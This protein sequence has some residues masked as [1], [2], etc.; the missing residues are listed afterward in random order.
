MLLDSIDVLDVL[1]STDIV[2]IQNDITN[3]HPLHLYSSLIMIGGQEPLKWQ[4]LTFKF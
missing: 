1:I 4:K 2:E 3:N